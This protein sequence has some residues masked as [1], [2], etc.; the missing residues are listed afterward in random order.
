MRLDELEHQ[1]LPWPCCLDCTPECSA[2]CGD[3]ARIVRQRGK[4]IGAF[5]RECHHELVEGG[6]P[7]ARPNIPRRPR[8]VTLRDLQDAT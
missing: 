4:V 1:K 3:P 2:G 5:C 6:I 7:P 8:G